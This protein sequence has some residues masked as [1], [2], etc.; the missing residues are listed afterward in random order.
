MDRTTTVFGIILIILGVGGYVI[1]GMVSAT[2][3]I[4]AFFGIVYVILGRLAAKENLR[5]HMMHA[6]A[7]LT[8]ILIIPT[9]G[10]IGDLFSGD[11]GAAVISRS[12]TAIAA[13]IY[14][15]LCIKSFIDAR[16]VRD[17]TA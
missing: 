1:S 7:A 6:A 4:P 2:A 11:S 10:A 9:V 14:L 3:L 8:I 12:L 17:A 5:K 15:F 16:K 13:I